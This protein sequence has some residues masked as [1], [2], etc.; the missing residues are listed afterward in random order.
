MPYPLV[1]V[2]LGYFADRYGFEIVGT[3][4]PGGSTLSDPSSSELAALVA[5]VEAAGITAIFAETTE[6]TALAEAVAAEAGEAIAVVDLYTGSLGE[7]GSGAETLVD[8]LLTNA[9]RIAEV[10]A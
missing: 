10:L 4:V 7:K 5:E 1:T 8:M 2:P 9:R 3:V 6:P